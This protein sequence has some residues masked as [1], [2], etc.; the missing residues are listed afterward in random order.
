M[1]LNELRHHRTS[2]SVLLKWSNK[3][4]QLNTQT[5]HKTKEEE[6]LTIFK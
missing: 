6:I 1:L 5:I 4:P 3:K 2:S